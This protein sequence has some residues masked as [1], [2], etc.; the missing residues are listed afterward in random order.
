MSLHKDYIDAGWGFQEWDNG[1][2]T[3]THSSGWHVSSVGGG[4]HKD[5]FLLWTPSCYGPDATSTVKYPKCLHV[6]G[7][8]YVFTS[9]WVAIETYHSMFDPLPLPPK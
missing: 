5:Q 9:M 3:A 6:K 2:A 1:T 7:K 8:P 4:T